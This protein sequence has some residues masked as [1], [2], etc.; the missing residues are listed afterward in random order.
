MA[1]LNDY[2]FSRKEGLVDMNVLLAD[3]AFNKHSLNDG[4]HT[5]PYD[6]GFIH[7]GLDQLGVRMVQGIDEESFKRVLSRAQHATIGLPYGSDPEPDDWEE[8]LEGGLQTALESQTI[9]FEVVGVTRATTHQIVRSRRAAFHQQSMRASFFGERPD[10][11]MPESVWRNPDVKEKWM[12]AIQASHEAYRAACDADVSYQDARYILPIGTTTY[13]MCEYTV[14]EFLNI[15]AYRACSMFQWEICETVRQMGRILSAEYPW[16]EKYIKISCE[17]VQRCT[18]Q[19][20]EEVEEQCDFP[21]AKEELR[22]Y[23]PKAHRINSIK[24]EPSDQSSVPVNL[25]SRRG[26]EGES[27]SHHPTG[28]KIVRT[29]PTPIPME[30]MVGDH[31]YQGGDGALEECTVEGCGV[32]KAEHLFIEETRS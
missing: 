29:K 30:Y 20:W 10:F 11:R 15:Y 1:K 13:I 5:S 28:T 26:D 8:M 7:V 31:V 19:G 17:K 22:T 18:F 3:R 6:N 23:K 14:R 25:S 16:L 12:T 27:R 9:V 21:W 24:R 32:V 4:H 2:L